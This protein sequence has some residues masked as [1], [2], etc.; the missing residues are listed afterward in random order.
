MVYLIAK[1][2]IPAVFGPYLGKCE[3][4]ENVP[5]EEGLIFAANHASYLDHFLV[6]INIISRFNKHARFLAKKEH[7]DTFFQN[8]WHR[9][10][11]AIPIDRQT[12]GREGL[13]KAV[14][15][16]KNGGWIMIYPEGTRTLTG[17]MQ[18]AKT[19]V[20]R[21]ALIAH[22]P[23]VPMGVTNS[24]E[25]WPKWKKLPKKGKMAELFIGKPLYFNEYYG[26][27]NDKEALRK[28]TT[29]IMKKIAELSDQEYPFDDCLLKEARR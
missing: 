3:G 15:H 8:L 9:Y 20:A 18:R 7:F 25:I 29:I 22:V 12:G 1:K 6:G 14:E 26:K 28:V 24:F 13:R 17:K 4:I 16:L 19:G 23:V 27:E 11:K 10:L 21:L 5:K 2:I